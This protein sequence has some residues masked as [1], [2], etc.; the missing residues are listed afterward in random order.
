MK[1]TLLLIIS[2]FLSFNII[3]AQDIIITPGGITSN[4]T[5]GDTSAVGEGTDTLSDYTDSTG[6][7]INSYGHVIHSSPVKKSLPNPLS[8]N[9]SG[10]GGADTVM[11]AATDSTGLGEGEVTPSDDP[12]DPHN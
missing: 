12:D 4:E 2:I 8:G 3:V 11:T 5:V 9:I 1:K 7:G 10:L 6:I